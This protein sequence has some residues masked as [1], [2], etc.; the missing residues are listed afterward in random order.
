MANTN[1]TFSI[2]KNNI[3]QCDAYGNSKTTFQQ[4]DFVVSTSALPK[5]FPSVT[6]AHFTQLVGVNN[7]SIV[8]SV[9]ASGNVS[10]HD[11]WVTNAL[12]ATGLMTDG[13]YTD[14][15]ILAETDHPPNRGGPIKQTWIPF[16]LSQNAK[17]KLLSEIT[18]KNVCTSGDC[19]ASFEYYGGWKNA[20]ISLNI[21]VSANLTDYCKANPA[22]CGTVPTFPLTPSGTVPAFPLTP[23]GTIP[24]VPITPPG[25]V[26]L[27]PTVPIA[28]ITPNVSPPSFLQ[29]YWW[30]FLVLFLLVVLMVVIVIIVLNRQ[31]KINGYQKSI[32]ATRTVDYD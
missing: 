28:T 15:V 3:A 24:I 20:F 7:V 21:S 2:T 8:Y 30:I 10:G 11:D 19:E 16:L 31:G 1:I 32:V 6:L 18:T 22:I 12:A 25:S 17:F 5:T 26:P 13:T 23:A 14:T 9:S 29:K 27:P 4:S